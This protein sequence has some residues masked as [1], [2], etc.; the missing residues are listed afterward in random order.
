MIDIKDTSSVFQLAFGLNAVIMV[1]FKNSYQKRKEFLD[2]MASEIQKH[3]GNSNIE[4]QYLLN[5]YPPYK[6][7]KYAFYFFIV[8]SISSILCSFCYL[9]E[10]ALVP[11]LKISENIFIALSVILILVNPILYYFYEFTLN[12]SISIIKEKSVI[13]K[14]DAIFMS[15]FMNILSESKESDEILSKKLRETEKLIFR[16][17]ISRIKYKLKTNP[18]LHPLKW[19][20]NREMEK[21]VNI[22]LEE[23]KRAQMKDN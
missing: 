13:T 11:D 2:Y 10:A 7:I 8:L 12:S 19:Y 22:I 4:N 9:V 14:D 17:K 21:Y 1:I 23:E 6:K 18:F 20:K 15:K 5:C 16:S 3:V